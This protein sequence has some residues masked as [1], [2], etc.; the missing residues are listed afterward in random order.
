MLLGDQLQILV[1]APVGLLK[2]RVDLL[3]L[4]LDLADLVLGGPPNV[5]LHYELFLPLQKMVDFFAWFM[6]FFMTSV[7][8]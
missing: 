3:D 1:L 8:P 6:T 7:P 4:L 2:L 5:L